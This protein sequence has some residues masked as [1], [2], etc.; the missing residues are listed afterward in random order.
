M[1]NMFIDKS[2]HLDFY[3]TFDTPGYVLAGLILLFIVLQIVTSRVSTMEKA[4]SIIEKI[5]DNYHYLPKS[6]R[7]YI[8]FILLS[9]SAGICEEIIFRLF[10]FSYLLE[11]ANLV[12][13]ILLTNVIFALTHIGSGKQNI[14]NAFILGL[15][16]TT[17]YYFTSNIWL[18]IILHIAIDIGAGALGYY[19]HE[20]KSESSGS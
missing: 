19:A 1:G 9:A 16:F 8:W 15:V 13:A 17:I 12:T 18:A 7:E 4:E 3:P 6:K 2:V 11:M 5:K 10:M 20:K 14:T